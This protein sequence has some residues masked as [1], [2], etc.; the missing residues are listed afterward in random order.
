MSSTAA[1]NCAFKLSTPCGD[2]AGAVPKQWESVRSMTEQVL[3][4]NKQR[5]S[6]ARYGLFEWRLRL[7]RRHLPRDAVACISGRGGMPRCPRRCN[8]I[9]LY[10]HRRQS[11][12]A[13][14]VADMHGACDGHVPVAHARTLVSVESWKSMLPPFKGELQ[15]DA[16]W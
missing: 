15:R 6:N 4:S 7:S 3:R 9:L 10:G 11:A 5:V 13:W 1:L 12:S 2:Y 8:L 16:V 14:H